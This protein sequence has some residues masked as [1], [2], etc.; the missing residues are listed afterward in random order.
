[1]ARRAKW[2]D[3]ERQR[4]RRGVEASDA[5]SHDG[6]DAKALGSGWWKALTDEPAGL[7]VSVR[8]EEPATR[9]APAW[10]E[11]RLPDGA[12]VR[13]LPGVDAVTFA[14]YPL[15][16]PRLGGGLFR[17]FVESRAE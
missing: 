15:G 8:V 3:Q 7:C 2:V 9:C 10:V 16:D 5:A 14:W 11:L 1:M 13:V 4:E 17:L 12:L 6:V